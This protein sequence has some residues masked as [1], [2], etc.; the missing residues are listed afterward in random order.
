MVSELSG[1]LVGL[2]ST[3]LHAP[4]LKAIAFEFKAEET[5]TCLSATCLRTLATATDLL[6]LSSTL[7]SL[8][9][10]MKSQ[11]VLSKLSFAAVLVRAVLFFIVTVISRCCKWLIRVRR[12]RTFCGACF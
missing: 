7:A 6:D 1:T 8:V 9:S 12:L 3:F 11:E 2:N 10:E 5:G 4:G